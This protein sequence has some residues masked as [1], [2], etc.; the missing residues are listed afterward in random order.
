MPLHFP[1]R[2]RADGSLRSS[3]VLTV[4]CVVA[5]L[6]RLPLLWGQFLDYDDGIMVFRNEI[7][8]H[9]SWESLRQI[10]LTNYRGEM[11]NPMHVANM[12]NWAVASGA[13]WSYSAVNLVW[14]SLLILLVYRFARLFVE[15]EPWRLAAT[16]LFAVHC[17]NTDTIGWVS[18]RCH[19]M[20]MMFLFGCLVLWQKYLDA[21]V[22]RRRAL[23][24]GLAILSGCF[25]IYNKG[26]F[27]ST[28]G[29]LILYEIY[30]RRK[31]GLLALVD[32]L[33]IFGL[34]A[35]FYTLSPVTG[36]LD[37]VGPLP[38]GMS[39][40]LLALNDPAQLVEAVARLLIPGPTSIALRPYPAF[41]LFDHVAGASLWALRWPPAVNL[42]ILALLSGLLIWMFLQ[43]LRAPLILALM[44]GMFIMPV[45][46]TKWYWPGLEFAFRYE[47]TPSAFFAV[48]VASVL[49]WAWPTLGRGWRVAVAVLGVGLLS[50]HAGW[51]YTQSNY[52]A[53]PHRYW[54]A[55]IRNYPDSVVCYEK[56]ANYHVSKKQW[57]QALKH[58]TE[59]D[60]IRFERPNPRRMTTALPI[61]DT[62]ER[63]GESSLALEN[64]QR[65][66]LV[67]NLDRERRKEVR[68]KIA[69]LTRP[70]EVEPAPPVAP[71]GG[72]G[73][74]G[75]D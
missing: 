18:A 58:F 67:D 49:A 56:A 66:L 15:E 74:G 34:G 33:P 31:P 46:N 24:Y 22:P 10:V 64:Y 73:A 75:G 48:A 17:V 23:W 6:V 1:S 69:A 44:A 27:I 4:I 32:K 54:D 45:L 19:L 62:L 28:G 41:S 8:S 47:L 61:A 55:C 52:W 20:G 68:A 21:E 36:R 70:P 37:M 5:F 30:R 13:Y 2:L 38:E 42:L 16:A 72:A 43:K 11:Q 29:L 57:R 25:A 7:V 63:M 39:V 60:R 51:S 3:L 65:S 9:P 71:E 53:S 14:Y 26:I 59:Q 12:L 40:S 50:W 35:Y